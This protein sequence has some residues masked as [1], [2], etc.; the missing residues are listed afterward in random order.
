[1]HAVPAVS[2]V[3][4]VSRCRCMSAA[5][6]RCC[7]CGVCCRD[8]GRMEAAAGVTG[9]P[10]ARLPGVSTQTANMG[11]AAAAAA[12][13]CLCACIMQS[14]CA[15]LP[16]SRSPAL[17]LMSPASAVAGMGTVGS[18][19]KTAAAQWTT[20]WCSTRP[21]TACRRR[22]QR[23][24]S[25]WP[26]CGVYRCCQVLVLVLLMLLLMLLQHGSTHARARGGR[27]TRAQEAAQTLR[28][29]TRLLSISQPT[30]IKGHRLNCTLII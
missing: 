25:S 4:V 14:S 18:G 5:W 9:S 23:W 29:L 15:H 1:M 27:N 28:T 20:C 16:S 17:C 30:L 10:A 22:W 2:V 24:M 12:K 19:R 7:G 13:V 3:S 8:R 26:K 11:G 6:R 21:H